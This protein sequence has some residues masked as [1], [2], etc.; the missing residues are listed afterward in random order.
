MIISESDQMA[1]ARGIAAGVVLS[2]C[3]WIPLVLA[4]WSCEAGATSRLD[5]RQ[6]HELLEEL[7]KVDWTEAMVNVLPE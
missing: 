1:P 5:D 3:F 4:I 6:A 7:R 2:L